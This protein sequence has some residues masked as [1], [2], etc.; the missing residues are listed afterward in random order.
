VPA[1][2]NL[3]TPCFP[4]NMLLFIANFTHIGVS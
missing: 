4:F 3:D 1:E 2:L